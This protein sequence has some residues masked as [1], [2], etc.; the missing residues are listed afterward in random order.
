MG[1]QS[2]KRFLCILHVIHVSLNSPIQILQILQT[3]II[4]M[5]NNCKEP[6]YEIPAKTFEPSSIPIG[7][8]LKN[9]KKLFIA[10]KVKYF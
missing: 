9:A 3:R 4:Q 7:S 10:T 6:Y 1:L 2:Y 5:Q 8:K